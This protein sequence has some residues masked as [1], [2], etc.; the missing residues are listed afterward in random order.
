MKRLFI[1]SSERSGSNLVRHILGNHPRGIA[2]VA[3]HFPTNLLPMQHC[4]RQGNHLDTEALITDML[5]LARHHIIPW[6]YDI[7]AD[8]V[9]P[10]VRKPG[11]W[12]CMIALYDAIAS[13]ADKS[14]WVCKDNRLFDYVDE[15]IELFPDT[16]FIYLVRDG[17]DVALSFLQVPGGPKSVTEA[18]QLWLAEQQACMR[19][20]EK[21]PD[22]CVTIRYEDLL[23]DPG[24]TVKSLCERIQIP[25]EATM[26]ENFQAPSA[27]AQASSYWSNLDKPL[28][29][30]NF[31]KWKR[32]MSPRCAAYY[33]GVCAGKAG[34]M[35]QTLGYDVLDQRYKFP[36]YNALKPRFD[37]VLKILRYLRSRFDHIELSRRRVKKIALRKIRQ[38]RCAS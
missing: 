30:E 11:F 13:T 17:R 8:L 24:E 27:E 15:I 36:L 21:Y 18:A 28:L 6:D 31:N 3:V 23:T 38:N 12:G 34:H 7:S 5:Y 32:D 25:Y 9:L 33:Q 1:L 37:R 4:Y 2:P 10:H 35:L 26:L 22:R 16:S 20:V 14:F 29:R 19:V